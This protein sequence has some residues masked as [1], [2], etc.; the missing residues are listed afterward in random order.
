MTKIFD[1]KQAFK[2][3]SDGTK[4]FA[5]SYIS[6][7]AG[8]AMAVWAKEGDELED[9]MLELMLPNACVTVDG[10]LKEYV[11]PVAPK[12]KA[13]AAAS[14]PSTGAPDSSTGAKKKPAAA[15]KGTRKKLKVA[16]DVGENG[17]SRG[18]K[19]RGA[20]EGG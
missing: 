12:A 19:G 13:K 14:E 16:A 4:T 18:G 3:W 7:L 15:V 20:E 10:Q 5:C 6:G 17:G 1:G 9:T 11:A 2:L 8:M